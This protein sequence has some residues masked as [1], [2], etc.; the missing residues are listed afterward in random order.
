MKK[1]FDDHPAHYEDEDEMKNG[2]STNVN[3]NKSKEND[4]DTIMAEVDARIK[5][6]VEAHTKQALDSMEVKILASLEAHPLKT[7]FKS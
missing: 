3:M 7:M 4:I 2:K 1:I 5:D 6:R